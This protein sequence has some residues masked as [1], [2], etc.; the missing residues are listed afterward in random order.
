MRSFLSS[1]IRSIWCKRQCSSWRQEQRGEVKFNHCFRWLFLNCNQLVNSGS[2]KKKNRLDP[3]EPPE[4]IHKN[5]HNIWPGSMKNLG[6]LTSNRL[7]GLEN[8]RSSFTYKRVTSLLLVQVLVRDI[9]V[10]E[11]SLFHTG[12]YWRLCGRIKLWS[13][14]TL[15]TM[16]VNS[17]RQN[18][19]QHVPGFCWVSNLLYGWLSSIFLLQ[20][21]PEC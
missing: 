7:I 6:Q 20:F 14:A 12:A 5:K 4:N 11:K 21:K 13:I 15:W 10:F 17:F 8:R 18:K 16:S 3:H 19:I 1:E 2:K 9:W